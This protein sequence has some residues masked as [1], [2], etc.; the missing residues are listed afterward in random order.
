MAV[1]DRFAERDDVRRDAL[2]FKSVKMSPDPPVPGLYFI[3]YANAAAAANRGVDFLQIAFGEE[4][5]RADAGTGF[6]DEPGQAR[7]AFAQPVDDL[8]H[9]PRVFRAGL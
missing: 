6:G 3:G 2:R 5:L 4:Y 9:A 7:A 8:D 1:A